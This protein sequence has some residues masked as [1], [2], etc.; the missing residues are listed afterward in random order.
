MLELSTREIR[1]LLWHIHVVE[2]A[3]GNEAPH[4]ST[5][6]NTKHKLNAELETN[7]SDDS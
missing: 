3:F 6:D 2:S 4:Q 5:I 7:G 1:V